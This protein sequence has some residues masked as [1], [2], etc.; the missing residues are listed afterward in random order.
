M[1]RISFPAPSAVSVSR[2]NFPAVASV[3]FAITTFPGA[4]VACGASF[5]PGAGGFTA[6]GG[7]TQVYQLAYR[8]AQAAL[9]PSRFQK[10]LEPCWN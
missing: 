7:W 10:T 4:V 2:S 3:G 8:Q 6:G 9:E 1:S 5:G